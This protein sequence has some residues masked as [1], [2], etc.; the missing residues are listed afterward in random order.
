ME[1][2]LKY[3]EKYISIILI[4]ISLIFI[5]YQ[6]FELIWHFIY[7]IKHNIQTGSFEAET[8]ARPVAGLF[9]GVLLSLEILQ[10]IRLYAHDH[11]VKL[12]VILIVG[13]IAVTR[14]IL[15]F[16]LESPSPLM[17]ISVA[18]LIISLCLGY[19]LV[20]KSEKN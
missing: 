19:F 15:M 17:E 3:F 1:T 14:K 16:E 12:K 5:S 18:A 9:F 20:S 6:I 8:N 7:K 4:I 2:L 13:I 10:T 11:S